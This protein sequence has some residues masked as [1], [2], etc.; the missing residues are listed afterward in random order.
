MPSIAQPKLS[1]I[2]AMLEKCSPGARIVAKKHHF[3]VLDSKGGIYRGLPLGKH[4]KK[5]PEIELGHVRKM[6]R[7]LGFEDCAQ[8]YFGWPKKDVDDETR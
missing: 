2:E 6:S 5:D 3:W 7:H 4:G 8:R 1:A